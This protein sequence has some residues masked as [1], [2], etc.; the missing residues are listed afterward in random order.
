[1]QPQGCDIMQTQSKISSR[2]LLEKVRGLSFP[3]CTIKRFHVRTRISQLIQK[4]KKKKK[5]IKV[6][7]T[8]KENQKANYG[9]VEHPGNVSIIP[10]N[11]NY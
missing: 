5:V 10:D 11:L 2:V 9:E 4:K 8:S 6:Q 3:Q 7:N 1:M